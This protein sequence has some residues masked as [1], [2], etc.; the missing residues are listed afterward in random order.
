MLLQQQQRT[1]L[2]Y[3]RSKK[4]RVLLLLLL[5][6]RYYGRAYSLCSKITTNQAK[7]GQHATLWLDREAR[8]TT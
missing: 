7:K 3:L 6:S 5:L 1:V 2:R 8:A 4:L